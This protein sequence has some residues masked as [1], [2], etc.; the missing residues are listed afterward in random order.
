[1]SVG[2]TI[3]ANEGYTFAENCKF[4]VNG[5]EEIVDMDFTG[6]DYES[7]TY[8]Y[9]WTIPEAAAPDYAIHEVYVYGYE[10]PVAGEDSQE[11]L[12]ITVPEDANYHIFANKWSPEWWDNDADDDFFGIFVEGTYYSV[13][14]TIE[15][16]EGYYFADD[17][18]FYV[19][20]GQE[21]VDYDY[22]GLDDEDNAY[23]YVWTIP[24]MAQ[25]N[26]DG[27]NGIYSGKEIA[28]VRYYN[29]TGQEMKQPSGVTIVVTT[30]TD[31]TTST[32]KT[33]KK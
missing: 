19:N 33:L 1:M 27:I 22:T 31:G 14:M 17:C 7:N 20:E 30:Y 10:S 6:I 18:V 29:L 21:L 8:A 24:E 32:V 5:S 25:G 28:G 15:A 3:E 11:H 13:G 12:N 2:M 26:M 9:V 4:Y 23:V 16:N